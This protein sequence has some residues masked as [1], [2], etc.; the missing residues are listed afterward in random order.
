M[1][2][3]SSG[4]NQLRS[5]LEERARGGAWGAREALGGG[6]RLQALLSQRMEGGGRWQVEFEEGDR[7]ALIR[8]AAA[9]GGSGRVVAGRGGGAAFAREPAALGKLLY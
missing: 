6:G 9:A 4:S 8:V 2:L 7:G 1:V 3:G 5:T